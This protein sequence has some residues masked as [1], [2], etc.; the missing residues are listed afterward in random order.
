MFRVRVPREDHLTDSWVQPVLSGDTF[1]ASY[2]CWLCCN[3]SPLKL[4]LHLP[5]V[6]S[7]GEAPV[8]LPQPMDAADDL[9]YFPR[10]W[11]IWLSPVALSRRSIDTAL[12]V[13]GS[14]GCVLSQLQ[15]GF[16][17]IIA[18]RGLSFRMWTIYLFPPCG[19][20]FVQLFVRTPESAQSSLYQTD[21]NRWNA[22]LNIAIC[23][24]FCEPLRSLL[25]IMI[26][27]TTIILQEP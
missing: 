15:N 12:L 22:Q 24:S 14:P 27:S 9:V 2:R 25:C 5:R 7:N 23:D 18:G 4:I 16:A 26:F 1:G 20:C 11:S 17:H 13:L 3:R 8:V 6:Q 10:V 19:L 21:S